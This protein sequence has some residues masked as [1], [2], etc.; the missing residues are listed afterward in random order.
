M[1]PCGHRGTESP[2]WEFGGGGREA[3]GGQ[4]PEK[5]CLE[6]QEL[7]RCESFCILPHHPHT[8]L[9][10]CR[11]TSCSGPVL[12]RSVSPF[13]E[14]KCT[15]PRGEKLFRKHVRRFH[16]ESLNVR[17]GVGNLRDCP[18]VQQWFRGPVSVKCLNGTFGSA[19]ASFQNQFQPFT[20][21]DV[22]PCPSIAPW[23]RSS[24]EVYQTCGIS[25]LRFLKLHEWD[26]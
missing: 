2:S 1:S 16:S 20:L 11:L 17:T 18:Q 14:N 3:G 13:S 10:S 21:K 12:T 24:P 15:S 6:E 19:E 5:L 25:A 9:D 26:V 23:I 4:T 8:L 22:C 7:H